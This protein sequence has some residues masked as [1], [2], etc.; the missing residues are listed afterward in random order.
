[1]SIRRIVAGMLLATALAASSPARAACPQLY[2]GEQ[3]VNDLQT[4][5]ISLRNLDEATFA[6]AGKRLEAGVPCAGSPA[7]APIFASAYRYLGA[8]HFLQKDEARARAW[9]RVALELDP[10][11]EW[12]AGELEL[13]SPMR[14]LFEEE[15]MAPKVAA[16][17][18]EG[19]VLAE[20]AGSR[21]L[22]DGR[23]LTEA[24]AT[25]DRPHVLQQVGTSDRTVRGTWLI[26]GNAIPPQF[27]R[28]A[29]LVA[30]SPLEAEAKEKE[31]KRKERQV[32]TNAYGDD[33]VLKVERL[34][35][36]EK[37]PLM[38]AGALGILG[39]GGIYA[40]TFATH[41]QFE[42]ATTRA[43]AEEAQAMNNALI[44]ASGGVLLLGAGIGYW[45]IILDGG[46]GLGVGGH[47]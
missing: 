39:A 26:D 32:T 9:F 34:R 6:S 41:D 37:T 40:A 13:D 30:D 2:T 20:P 44:L 11:Y 31:R 19:R 28:D 38:I 16:A 43:E 4:L 22:L 7:P 24:A 29:A 15:R 46:A 17:P 18:I 27:L 23:P 21:F 14:K 25:P 12:D 33:G 45:A 3:L 47:F 10:T 42:A 35:P 1:M 8:Y 5:Q 36:P